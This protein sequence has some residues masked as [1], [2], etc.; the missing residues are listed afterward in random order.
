MANEMEQAVHEMDTILQG[1]ES[2]WEF[3]KITA[4]LRDHKDGSGLQRGYGGP[5]KAL[6]RQGLL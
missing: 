2:I 1:H 6:Y 5:C 3:G 4:A